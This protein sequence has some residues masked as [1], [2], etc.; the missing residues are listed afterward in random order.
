MS[1]EVWVPF[2]V[3][4]PFIWCIDI[5]QGSLKP[6]ITDIFEQKADNQALYMKLNICSQ[7]AYIVMETNL[8]DT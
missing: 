2:H 1:Y 3:P 7:Y 4:R 6:Q 8:T 5:K